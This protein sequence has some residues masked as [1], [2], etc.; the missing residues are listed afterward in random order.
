[1]KLSNFPFGVS[2]NANGLLSS[3]E[4]FILLVSK[5][6]ALTGEKQVG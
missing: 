5:L 1:M 3:E 2:Q 4:V 6:I